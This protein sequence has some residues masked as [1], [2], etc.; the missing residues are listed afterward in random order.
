MKRI[1]FIIYLAGVTM[2]AQNSKKQFEK[3]DT[4]NLTI[5]TE[6]SIIEVRIDNS[7]GDPDLETLFQFEN[8]N[9][10][11]FSFSGESIKGKFYVVKVKEY[12]NGELIDTETLFDERGTEYFR[13]DSTQTSFKLLTKVDKEEIKLW[14]KGK[15]FGSKQAYFPKI[16]GNGRYAV[17]D[18]FGSQE[19][20]KENSEAAFHLMSVIT[21]NR[22]E[23]GLGSYCR[24]A[25]SEIDP[26]EFG[27]VFDIPHYFLIEIEFTE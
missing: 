27:K 7:I 3:R 14:I 9:Q 23:D 18:F 8:I 19:I 21:P 5:P 26:E 24:V 4:G 10:S 1:L 6:E 13:V 2:F 15:R 12:L 20:L 22:S 16:L 17:K 11:E 25:Q